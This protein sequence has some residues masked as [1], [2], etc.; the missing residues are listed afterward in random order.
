MNNEPI[1]NVSHSFQLHCDIIDANTGEVLT[2][3]QVKEISTE[4]SDTPDILNRWL[5]CFYRG[6]RSGRV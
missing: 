5:D 6:L 2:R 3:N 4:F 1:E